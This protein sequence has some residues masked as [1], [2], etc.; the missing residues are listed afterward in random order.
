MKRSSAESLLPKSKKASISFQ[1]QPFSNNKTTIKMKKFLFKFLIPFVAFLFIAS[2]V[3]TGVADAA[4]HIT[5]I[6]PFIAAVA[7]IAV[8]FTASVYNRQKHTS[9]VTQSGVEVE[10]WANYIVE[11]LWKDNQFLQYAF[12]D[13]DKVL[14][15]KIVHIPQPGGLPNVVKNRTTT[16]AV[17]VTRADTDVMYGLDTYTTDPTKIQKAEEIEV[18]YDKINS[19]YGDH[20]G[21]VS[22]SVADNAILTWLK[23]IPQTSYYYTTGADVDAIEGATGNRKGF[24]FKDVN[25]LKTKMNKQKVNKADRFLLLSSDMLQQFTESLTETAQNSFNQF[26][27]EET[28]VMGKYAGFTFFE[29][30]DVAFATS[31]TVSGVTTTTISAYGAAIGATTN[32]VALAW[33]KDCVARALGE[34]VFFEDTSNPLYYGDV[35]SALLRFGGRRRR[36]DDSG[37]IAI[38]QTV[39]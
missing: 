12:S 1:S 2:P 6:S 5:H 31:V 7:V 14:G 3:I 34:V 35:Y 16:P 21:Q 32:D 23:D 26:Y 24:T 29:R 37:V 19:V 13:D 8:A 10:M 15:G 20:A 18:S 33:Q 28:G 27:N 17:A 39:S 25:K 9:G 4:S 30:S 11:R 36:G 22:Q 38:V